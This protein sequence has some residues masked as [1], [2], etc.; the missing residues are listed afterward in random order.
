MDSF[1]N[2]TVF[3]LNPVMEALKAQKRR[4][5]KL[6]LEKGKSQARL[7]SLIE[8]AHENKVPIETIPKTTF[9]KK[10]RNHNHQGVIGIFAIIKALELEELIQQAFKR[11]ALP[12]LA[13]LDSIQDP[14]NLGAIIRSAETLG[15][16]GI[17]LPKNR[18]SAINETVA[19]CSSGAIEH[20]PISWVTNLTRGIEQLKEA[21]FWIAGIAPDGEIP[22]YQYKFDAPMVLLIGGEEKGIRPLL[23]KSCDVTLKIPM[24]GSL[25][26]LNASAAAAVVFYEALRQKNPVNKN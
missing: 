11:S 12:T 19:K 13:A 20:L 22:C 6:I 7:K 24:E 23:K 25:E 10:Y 15:I 1:D 14:H 26:S 4:C 5:Y 9:Q 21:G 17:I 2:S 3:G 18:T 16:H 8:L